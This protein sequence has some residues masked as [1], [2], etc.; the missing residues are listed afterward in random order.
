MK[1]F[2]CMAIALFLLLGLAVPASAAD[3]DVGSLELKVEYRDKKITGGD[4]I[5]VRVGYVDPE[6]QVFRKVTS[7][8][9][10][11][12]IGTAAAVTQ[13]QNFYTA[14][15]STY[16]FLTYKAEVKNGIAK[17]TGIPRGLYLIHQETA[18]EGYNKL[19]SFLVTLPYKGSMEVSV[20]TKTEL[21]REAEP[22]TGS[23]R[24]PSSGNQK[25]PQT[26][27]L[28]WPIPWMAAAG[29]LLFA[30]GWW[31]FFGRRKDPQ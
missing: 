27:Q 8:D 15:K 21:E 2:V 26:G 18:A 1:Q 23:S 4:L 7:H 20:R 3:A 30:F 12:D 14:N 24:P 10:I 5:A 29:M 17:F 22:V 11:K 25:L 16:S 19:A 6:N 9:E 13:M 28:T 31:L